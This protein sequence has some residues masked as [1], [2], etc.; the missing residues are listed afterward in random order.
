MFT[1]ACLE[2]RAPL[3]LSI[4]AP[5]AVVPDSQGQGIGGKL[6]EYGLKVLSDLGVDLVFVLGHPEYYLR[7]G[8]EPAGKLGFAAPYRIAEK[9][10]DAWMVQA[11]NPEAIPAFSGKVVCAKKLDKPEY[12]RE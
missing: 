9:N 6:I 1:K 5:L 7:H 2:P 8:F 10:A 4:L 3:S 12:W 11:L